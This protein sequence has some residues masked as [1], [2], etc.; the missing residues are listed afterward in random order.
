MPKFK[1]D[2]PLTK[3]QFEK[4]LT[5]ASTPISEWKHD[6]KEVGTSGSHRSGDYT[7]KCMNQDRIAGKED[8]H[9]D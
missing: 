6:S 1:R 4:L 5:K 8:L 7:D 2:K 9:D 3:K